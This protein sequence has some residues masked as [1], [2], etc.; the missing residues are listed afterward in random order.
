M[1]E[2]QS[3]TDRFAAELNNTDQVVLVDRRSVNEVLEEQG[4]E[5]EGCT[6]EECAAEV[7]ALLGV[8]YMIN[9][10][11]GRIG[12]TFTI[13]AKMFFVATGVAERT[14][15]K[16]YSGPVDG[17]ITEIE[18]LAWDLMQLD[19]P[20]RLTNKQLGIPQFGIQAPRQKTRFEI[21]RAHV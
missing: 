13:D 10:S 21:G 7:G 1:L 15:S 8:K 11:I 14:K 3:L 4:Y 19:P 18:L 9:G 12:D 17:L 16:T 5:T 6:S 2:A 20:N